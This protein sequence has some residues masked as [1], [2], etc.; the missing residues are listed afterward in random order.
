MRVL[1][2]CIVLLAAQAKAATFT[3]TTPPPGWS[4]TPEKWGELWKRA[5]HFAEFLK[6]FKGVNVDCIRTVLLSALVKSQIVV[7]L[8]VARGAAR[9]LP[10]TVK[11]K[12]G[13][14]LRELMDKERDNACRPPGGGSPGANMEA[15]A[16]LGAYVDDWTI[17][18]YEADPD[19]LRRMVREEAQY[20]Y[21][22]VTPTAR[23][24]S[25][26]ILRMLQ[27]GFLVPAS[28]AAA[29]RALPVLPIINPKLFM[30]DFT[31]RDSL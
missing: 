5:N 25:P 24:E 26:W 28:E 22:L 30:P 19:L 29:V 15:I 6:H 12:D 21:G 2:V 11:P 10:L 20:L 3:S 31:P 13:P 7:S 4:G 8:D 18:D 16:K 17:H 14:K 1:A 9:D 27:L 23:P